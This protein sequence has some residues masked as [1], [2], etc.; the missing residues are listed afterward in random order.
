VGPARLIAVGASNLARLSLAVL[1]AERARVGGPVAM[2]TAAGFGRSYCIPSRFLIR[3]LGPIASSPLWNACAATD[4]GAR[5]RTT[6]LLMDV[7]NDLL[8]G[9]EVERILAAVEVTLARL[10]ELAERV[11]VVG[12]PIA[13]VRT[14]TKAQFLLVRTVLVP[15][16]PLTF[17]NA[18][19]GAERLHDVLRSLAERHG[20]VFREHR[21]EWYGFDP[22]HVRRRDSGR[23]VQEWLGAGAAATAPP[24]DTW[25]GRWRLRCAAPAERSLGGVRRSHAQPALH[26]ADGSS[27]SLW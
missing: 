21:S 17:A 20:A 5:T 24:W 23:A 19:A 7:G 12:L 26:F 9:L 27:L 4:P 3:G 13:T 14:V 11:I 25:M 6:A 8:Y 15:G 2:H 10:A 22:M 1:D 16:S 18:I